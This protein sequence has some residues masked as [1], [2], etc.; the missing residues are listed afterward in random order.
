MKF[1]NFSIF[2][3]L[4]ALLDSDPDPAEQNQCGSGSE[5]LVITRHRYETIHS[6]NVSL[7]GEKNLFHQRTRKSRSQK[8]GRY[9][10]IYNFIFADPGKERNFIV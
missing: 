6:P 2:V 5:T 1:L 3:G 8:N 9:I 7:G 4:F 10:Y